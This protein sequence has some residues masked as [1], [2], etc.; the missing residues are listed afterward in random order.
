MLIAYGY[1]RADGDFKAH[2]PDRIVIDA[3]G[4]MREGRYDMLHGL[5]L[6]EGDTVLVFSERD[7]G[8]GQEISAIR[9]FISQAGATLRVLD[10]PR[11]PKRAPGRGIHED[12]K[13]LAQTLWHTVGV[14]VEYLNSR[15]K[16]GPYARHQFNEAFGPRYK[17]S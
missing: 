14:S 4:T 10:A 9:D 7:L 13:A 3:P 5:G 6:R 8:G 2:N 15:M 1:K 16:H 17:K 12:D 11:A